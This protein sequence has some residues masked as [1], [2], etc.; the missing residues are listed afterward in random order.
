MLSQSLN[1]SFPNPIDWVI[2]GEFQP[3]SDEYAPIQPP[4]SESEILR[5]SISANASYFIGKKTMKDQYLHSS[6]MEVRFEAK[7]WQYTWTGNRFKR[8]VQHAFIVTIL[9]SCKPHNVKSSN[10]STNNSTLH[11]LGQYS[12]P[13]FFISSIRRNTLHKVKSSEILVASLPVIAHHEAMQQEVLHTLDTL[14]SSDDE[15]E[16]EEETVSKKRKHSVTNVSSAH[17]SHSNHYKKKQPRNNRGRSRSKSIIS[18]EDEEEEAGETSE[19][20]RRRGGHHMS[21]NSNNNSN[22]IVA[23]LDSGRTTLGDYDDESFSDGEYLPK[24]TKGTK[25]VFQSTPTNVHQRIKSWHPQQ[26]QASAHTNTNCGVLSYPKQHHDEEDGWLLEHHQQQPPSSSSIVSSMYPILLVDD[27]DVDDDDDL[28][29]AACFGVS[30]RSPLMRSPDR[31]LPFFYDP[32]QYPQPPQY[33]YE[34]QQYQ[35]QQ[36]QYHQQQQYYCPI[37]QHNNVNGNGSIGMT[38]QVLF[39]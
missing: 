7:P 10:T 34:H 29:S 27:N 12:S 28:F 37:M 22:E 14:A 11:I 17:H 6:V 20:E 38:A 25:E 33:Q 31:Q 35:Y 19:D 16:A 9:A 15:D 8:N 18:D 21:S 30:L 2:I 24:G 32:L 3:L 26:L 39:Q 13:S 5:N 4:I 1:A 23:G 36:P